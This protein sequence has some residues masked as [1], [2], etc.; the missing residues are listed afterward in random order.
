MN[1][2]A[3]DVVL[4]FKHKNHISKQKPIYF[5]QKTPKSS[6]LKGN[7]EIIQSMFSQAVTPSTKK[8]KN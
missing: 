4:C 3:P 1:F 6:I 5:V 7:I 2:P 8:K